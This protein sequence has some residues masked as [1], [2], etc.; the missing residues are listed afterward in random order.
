MKVT[1][2]R[3]DDLHHDWHRNVSEKWACEVIGCKKWQL[4]EAMNEHQ[5]LKGWE[6]QEVVR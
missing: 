5:K 1:I 6:I 2:I 3:N 4:E